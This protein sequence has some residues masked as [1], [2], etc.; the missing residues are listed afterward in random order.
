[1]KAF[2]DVTQRGFAYGLHRNG[3]RFCEYYVHS[4]PGNVSINAAY[5]T[6][7]RE[8]A[9]LLETWKRKPRLLRGKL[10]PMPGNLY[11]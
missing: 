10:A 4:G 2:I 9:S 6:A 7:S 11:R 5:Q 3:V 8:V 1:M